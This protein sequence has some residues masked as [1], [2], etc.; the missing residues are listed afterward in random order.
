MMIS[1]GSIRIVTSGTHSLWC[2]YQGVCVERGTSHTNMGGDLI[3]RG[4]IERRGAE[5]G[6][7]W[8]IDEGK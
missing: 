2:A 1:C 5:E 8:L 4:G 3:E 6:C 7:C